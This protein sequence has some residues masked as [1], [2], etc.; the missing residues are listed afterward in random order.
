MKKIALIVFIA[1]LIAGVF[2]YHYYKDVTEPNTA[3]SA[4]QKALYIATNSTFEDLLTQL[5]GDSIIADTASFLWVAEQKNFLIMSSQAIT[6]L[7]M[8]LATTT[9][10]TYS[11]AGIKRPSN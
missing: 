3:F 1:L 8:A 9:L 10:L 5:V 6:E 4:P 11:E 2:G 7:T